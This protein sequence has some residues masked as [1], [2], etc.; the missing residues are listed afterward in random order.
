MMSD[1]QMTGHLIRHH[2]RRLTELEWAWWRRPAT[3]ADYALM[4]VAVTLWAA[5]LVLVAQ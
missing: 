5:F 3:A 1:E 4:C 2:D